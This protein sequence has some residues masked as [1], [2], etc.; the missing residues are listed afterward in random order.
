MLLKFVAQALLGDCSFI[1][2]LRMKVI[3][4]ILSVPILPYPTVPN[5]GVMVQ[6]L[7]VSASQ[8][9]GRGCEP[10]P[11]HTTDFENCTHCLLD[12]CSMYENEM[13]KLNTKSYEWTS[14]L[15]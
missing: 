5:T 14:L 2:K 11:S 8:L 1:V 15:L 9:E 4:N 7:R 10:H 6:W 13:G 3:A 12:W